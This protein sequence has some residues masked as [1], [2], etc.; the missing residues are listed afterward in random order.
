M[1]A[2]RWKNAAAEDKEIYRLML[3]CVGRGMCVCVGG[4]TFIRKDIHT[5]I[6]TYMQGALVETGRPFVT[7]SCTSCIV[8]TCLSA[9]APS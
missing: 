9:R 4:C 3:G 6:H 8:T 5:Y 1:I 7:K 2:W